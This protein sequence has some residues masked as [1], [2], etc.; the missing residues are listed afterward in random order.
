MDDFNNHNMYGMNITSMANL[1]VYGVG[2]RLI[3]MSF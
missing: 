1:K 2:K 3:L